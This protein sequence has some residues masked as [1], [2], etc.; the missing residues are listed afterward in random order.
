ML[1]EEENK[2]PE[3][4]FEYREIVQ[5]QESKDL[6]KEQVSKGEKYFNEMEKDF[7]KRL[8]DLK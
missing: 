7:Q 4:N 5:T 3:S 8:K 2:Q 1:P 6:M